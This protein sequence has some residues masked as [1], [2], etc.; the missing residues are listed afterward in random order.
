MREGKY[1]IMH[2][3]DSPTAREF[4]SESLEE[5]GFLIRSAVD[6]QDMESLLSSDPFLRSAVDFFVLDME[7]PDM[8]G[9]QIGAI[10]E[11]T[12]GELEQVPFIIYSAKDQDF[13]DKMSAD[14]IE[15]SPGFKRNYKGY[16]GKGAG[17]EEKIIAII[18]ETFDTK[19]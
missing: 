13:V 5:A 11:S 12:Y 17:S 2:V 6:A 7:M 1:L 4:V 16:V 15:L 3:D 9:A 18:K 14:V 10:M 19:D 8:T